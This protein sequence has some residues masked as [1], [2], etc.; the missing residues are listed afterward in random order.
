MRVSPGSSLGEANTGTI[1]SQIKQLEK[2]KEKLEKKLKD[3]GDPKEIERLSQEIQTVYMEI[4]MLRATRENLAGNAR[5]QRAE[6]SAP[7]SAARD[8]YDDSVTGEP[9]EAREGEAA[10]AS[11][12]Q[13]V[14]V[15][16]VPGSRERET[17]PLLGRRPGVY[18]LE[19]DERGGR[20][21]AY[22]LEERDEQEDGGNPLVLP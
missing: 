9:G 22:E 7:K 2:R 12:A 5:A 6:P 14:S 13:A 18:S 3:A 11:A 17:P 20:R 15:D 8:R 10:E 4:A 19:V 16:T 21:V 1:D